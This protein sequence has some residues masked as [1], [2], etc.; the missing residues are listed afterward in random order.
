MWTQYRAN[1]SPVAP[2]DWAISFSWWG[3]IEVL[4]AAVDVEA[5]T[6]VLAGHGRALDVPAGAA[7]APG[8]VPGRLAG[9][10][11]LP[12]GEVERVALVRVDLDPGAGQELGQVAAG[13]LAVLGPLAD[14]EVD[15]AVGLVGEADVDQAGDQGQHLGDVA[16]GPW[17]DVGREHAKGGG[18]PVV[19][20][21][22]VLGDDER[23]Q[24]VVAG[25]VD[26]LVVDVGV[27][28]DVQDVV[29]GGGQVAAEDV[30]HDDVAQVADV[31][32]AVDR[33]PAQVDADPARVA[34]DERLLAPGERVVELQ[35]HGRF[36][37]KVGI[38]RAN[39]YPTR[40]PAAQRPGRRRW[41]RS[42]R[43]GR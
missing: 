13:Q 22:P 23:L 6:Q 28:A 36:G 30:E 38:G 24:R 11:G 26:D 7:R 21:G 15:V 34:G 3:K 41:R 18:D 39:S 37:S 35:G 12:E 43:P 19:D 10:G 16:A 17:R 33:D 8:R 29:A 27:V 4:A 32:L 5:A 1:G 31:G 25:G 14:G 9:L 42:P 20:P 2:S 40:V